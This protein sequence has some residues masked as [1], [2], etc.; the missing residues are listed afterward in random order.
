MLLSEQKDKTYLHKPSNGCKEQ[1][2]Y[3][4]DCIIICMHVRMWSI[5]IMQDV[6][7]VIFWIETGNSL[8]LIVSFL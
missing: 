4:M 3:C 8:S 2:G 6:N 7:S 5:I 1:G